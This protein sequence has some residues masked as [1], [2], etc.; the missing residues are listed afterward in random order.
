M[1]ILHVIT[2]YSKMGGAECMLSK[3]VLATPEHQHN[4]I[5]L[6]SISDIYQESL[7][8][9]KSSSSLGWKLLKTPS[10]L[11]KLARKIKET[12]PDVIQCWMYHANVIGS[13]AHLLARSK[14]KIF[15]GIHHSLSDYKSEAISVKTALIAS[16]ALKRLPS[17]LIYCSQIAREQHREFGLNASPD[18]YIP[19]GVDLEKFSYNPETRQSRAGRILTVGTA[20]RLHKSKG[21]PYLLESIR[22]TVT[23][24]QGITFL[25][26]GRGI[27]KSNQEFMELVSNAGAPLD[28]VELLGEVKDMPSFYE[29]ID[30][31]ILSSITE[32][33]P[34]VLVEA[35]ASGVPCITTNVGDAKLIVRDSGTT[36]AP[37]D[38][39]QLAEAIRKYA[40]MPRMEILELSK[41][42]RKIVVDNYSLSAV[43]KNYLAVWAGKS[44]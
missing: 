40:S 37:K 31:F 3:L 22:K 6:I 26:A 33:F 29:G 8:N 32:G 43:S 15:W 18:H 10:T 20:G 13:L 25:L 19:N 21:Y 14:S 27:H 11:L 17:G 38:S 39:E 24:S 16:R 35:M 12:N 44:P 28:R 41:K 23:T 7:S 5:S 1:R 4:I 34:N 9:A 36:V 30:V 42:A 2:N